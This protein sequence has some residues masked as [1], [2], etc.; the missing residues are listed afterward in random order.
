VGPDNKDKPLNYYTAN[1]KRGRERPDTQL[2][3][4]YE[5]QQRETRHTVTAQLRNAA[6]RDQTHSYC[7]TTKRSRERPDTQLLHNY[8]T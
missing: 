4:N 3:H 8:E 6:E 1:T 7:T 5:T 2:L